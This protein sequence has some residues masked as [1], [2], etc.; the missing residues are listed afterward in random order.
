MTQIG[1]KN[2]A[3]F[4]LTFERLAEL[5]RRV[6]AGQLAAPVSIVRHGRSGGLVRFSSVDQALLAKLALV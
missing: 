4:A 2:S 3:L 1:P 5:D 6:A